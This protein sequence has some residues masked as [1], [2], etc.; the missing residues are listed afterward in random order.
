MRIFPNKKNSI[1]L[2]YILLY[3]DLKSFV[4]LTKK[5]NEKCVGQAVTG[6]GSYLGPVLLVE[7]LYGQC[8]DAR[9]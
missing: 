8:P 7:P 2:K 1:I 3:K 9:V 5:N 6:P 4:F